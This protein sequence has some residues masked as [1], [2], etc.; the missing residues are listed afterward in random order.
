MQHMSTFDKS[1]QICD[2]FMLTWELLIST[3]E[4]ILTT[5]KK[6]NASIQDNYTDMRLSIYRSENYVLWQH[7]SA[8][9]LWLACLKCMST[10]QIIM[11]HVHATNYVDLQ[12]NHVYLQGNCVNMRNTCIF[13]FMLTS[14]L[15][16]STSEIDYLNYVNIRGN[17]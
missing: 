15:C 1:M 8:N 3:N 16:M 12:M 4:L 17:K 10:C 11:L 5:S 9:E 6:N 7:T 2:F 13:F 14:K